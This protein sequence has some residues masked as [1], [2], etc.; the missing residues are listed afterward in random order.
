M[1][2]LRFLGTRILRESISF[3]ILSTRTWGAWLAFPTPTAALATQPMASPATPTMRCAGSQ[4]S[5]SQA[6]I[7]DHT[8]R[9]TRVQDEGNGNGRVIK[10]YQ[11]D[12]LGRLM[13]VCEVASATQ[14]GITPSPAACGQDIAATGFLTSYQYGTLSMTVPQ[15]GLN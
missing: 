13:S 11:S 4:R 14:M 9:A 10:I 8:N 6:I 1:E 15:G 12:G 5:Q 2:S 3:S 7:I